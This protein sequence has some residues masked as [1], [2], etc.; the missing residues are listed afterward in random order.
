MN[1]IEKLSSDSLVQ[2]RLEAIHAVLRSILL[3]AAIITL[4][5]GASLAGAAAFVATYAWQVTPSDVGRAAHDISDILTTTRSVTDALAWAGRP[6]AP[7][8]GRR[9]VDM[10]H[11][12]PP[13]PPPPIQPPPIEELARRAVSTVVQDYGNV[14]SVVSNGVRLVEEHVP[15]VLGVIAGFASVIKGGASPSAGASTQ[16]AS[17]DF[18]APFHAAWS[19]ST[20]T[21]TDVNPTTTTATDGT[22]TVH[23]NHSHRVHHIVQRPPPPNFPPP[24]AHTYPVNTNLI[25]MFVHDPYAAW[26]NGLYAMQTGLKNRPLTSVIEKW[27][28][29][30]SKIDGQYLS[31]WLTSGKTCP[32]SSDPRSHFYTDFYSG[33]STYY[34]VVGDSDSALTASPVACPETSDYVG[35]AIIA[36]RTKELLDSYDAWIY[37]DA[38]DRYKK[39]AISYIPAPQP[40]PPQPN[41]PNKPNKSTQPPAP[42]TPPQ[43]NEPTQL[44][45]PTSPPPPP[46]WQQQSVPSPAALSPAAAPFPSVDPQPRRPTMPSPSPAY[47]STIDT[48][49]MIDENQTECAQTGGDS[50]LEL[51]PFLQE[52]TNLT[53]IMY[54]AKESSQ[55]IAY[56]LAS[57]L[58]TL[59]AE[60]EVVPQP[61]DLRTF[62]YMKLPSYMEITQ[63]GAWYLGISQSS[64]CSA[65]TTQSCSATPLYPSLNGGGG[66]LNLSQPT[67]VELEYVVSTI[68]IPLM[69]DSL[70]SIGHTYMPVYRCNQL[71]GLQ[72]LY[73]S[74]SCV[75][76]VNLTAPDGVPYT[77]YAACGAPQTSATQ[78]SPTL[79]SPP[80][81]P[82]LSWHGWLSSPPLAPPPLAQS[83]LLSMSTPLAPPPLAQSPPL[84]MSTPPPPPPTP[85]QPGVLYHG[86]TLQNATVCPNGISGYDSAYPT[87]LGGQFFF[88]RN[89][90]LACVMWKLA[91]TLCTAYPPDRLS[92][93]TFACL[94]N[95]GQG[96]AGI[97]GSGFT[98]Y[99]ILL[100]RTSIINNPMAVFVCPNFI[101]GME[102]PTTPSQMQPLP[103]PY[104]W[105]GVGFN[106]SLFPSP[107]PPSPSPPSP[108]WPPHPPRELPSPGEVLYNGWTPPIADC[109]SDGYDSAIPQYMGNVK[110]FFY[111][112]DTTPCLAW[113][114]AATLCWESEPYFLPDAGFPVQGFVGCNSTANLMVCPETVVSIN[115]WSDVRGKAYVWYGNE[116]TEVRT[117]M[118][119]LVAYPQDGAT[120]GGMFTVYSCGAWLYYNIIPGE[121]AALSPGYYFNS[122]PPLGPSLRHDAEVATVNALRTLESATGRLA[123]RAATSASS[124]VAGELERLANEKLP[125][126]SKAATDAAER[127]AESYAQRI[128]LKVE[129]KLLGTATRFAAK[130][131]DSPEPVIQTAARALNLFV[132]ALADAETPPPLP[133]LPPSP[134]PSPAPPSS[135][136]PP[137]PSPPYPIPP[138][139]PRPPPSPP[140]PPMP[141]L[142]RSPR[143]PSPPSPP[144]PPRPPVVHG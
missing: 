55:C 65:Q 27:W 107:P 92:L 144:S 25:R 77:E 62:Y 12:S 44:P 7:V 43:P 109:Q 126:L 139:P 71:L 74:P 133:P 90:S 28:N 78:H 15:V 125:G 50:L 51:Q 36:T 9:L 116:T 63:G 136:P 143:P 94:N 14:K 26:M 19:T 85:P 23:Q 118:Q 59:R 49:V 128:G 82:P 86:W 69:D 16:G 45:A 40:P 115:Y 72:P 103:Y 124:Y 6:D 32:L 10:Q 57:A 54:Y 37:D 89:D 110:L 4:L 24:P 11:Q 108:P 34:W 22:V 20:T 47:T 42:T 66:Y 73:D 120:A 121:V 123:R 87:A 132:R 2:K 76:V 104:V 60:V 75:T 100:A 46:P 3:V 111:S 122:P 81:P 21:T 13:S 88:Y 80:P 117:H 96:H 38:T 53:S 67:P 1:D 58:C 137:L 105:D 119:Y 84:S 61:G 5:L 18:S 68:I 127:Y 102:T 8:R 138:F 70:M 48:L 135:P 140:L 31:I 56:R 83:P 114:L 64:F 101:T 79:P 106:P 131:Y 52:A 29:S 98:G 142:P 99:E 30:T 130:V 33:P 112:N 129:H 39:S 95:I 91:A 93:D 41:E 97:C 35:Y 141:P 134:P 17:S 113:K